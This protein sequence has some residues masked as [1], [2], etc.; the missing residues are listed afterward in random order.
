M[1]KSKV[2]KE[3]S[4]PLFTSA[5]CLLTSAFLAC[6][7][8]TP[9]TKQVVRLNVHTEPPTLDPR[10]AIDSTSISIIQMCFEGLTRNGKNH[11]VD[12]A[13]AQ[14]VQIS[15]DGKIYT[16]FL[17][18]ALWS[19]GEKIKAVDFET[20]WKT[21]LSPH[22]A[23]ELGFDL[24][25]IKNAKA[26]KEGKLPLDQVGVKALDEKTLRVELENPTANFLQC[27]ASHSFLPIPSHVQ[28]QDP[29]WAE[30][31][32][33]YVGS[34][35]FKLKKW[36]H[37]YGLLLEKNPLYWDAD[38]VKL[39]E[40]E[41]SII[42]DEST[43]LALFEKGEL[44]WA[45]SPLSQLPLDSLPTLQKKEKIQ[46]HPV[47]G[48]YYFIFNTKEH[49]FTNSKI[50][51]AFSLAINRQAIIDNIIQGKQTPAMSLIP[52]TMWEAKEYFKD[53]S[54]SEAKLLFEEGLKE[55]GIKKEELAPITLSFNTTSA[56][57]K[58]A[59]A[60]QQQWQSA[61]GIRIEL[62]NMEWKV[63]LDEVA[64]HK[65]QIARMG[66]IASINDAADF[67]DV[68]RYASSNRNYSQWHNPEFSKLLDMAEQT[69]DQT[70]R[71]ALLQKAEA[72]LMEEM[73][74][75]PL[76]F[77]TASYLK[78]PYLKGVHISEIHEI[79]LKHAYVER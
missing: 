51:K 69:K 4:F 36:R 54:T 24:Y 50:R 38:A 75:A 40:I 76:Y 29:S 53:A 14:D 60:I 19:D 49:P 46:L 41:L 2:K 37:Y 3:F 78:K 25:V 71:K 34:G 44:D 70:A 32:S 7:S 1:E 55:L 17:R 57:H 42:E 73:P 23:S 65:F 20:S 67:L 56:H 11:S 45:G 47:S 43:E 62:K 63:F 9:S 35:P 5:F 66:G 68:Y 52:P 13:L 33:K 64:H 30:K 6:S 18:D 58:I 59:Q 21:I 72:C 79:D 61:F 26:A 77:Y 22:F 10:K 74:I 31:V 48:V 8:P 27:V 39:E 12:L 28:Q 15:E 16:F